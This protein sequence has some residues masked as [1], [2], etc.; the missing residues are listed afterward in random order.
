MK[1]R[2]IAEIAVEKKDAVQKVRELTP[3]IRILKR[4][5]LKTI[6]EIGT[7][8]GG[9]IYVWHKIAQPDAVIISID[10]P[11]GPFGG[12]YTLKEMKVIRGYRR[13]KQKLHLMRKDS[14]RSATRKEL[15]RRLK[16]R[17]IDF[18]MI[19]GDHRYAGVR[20]DWK[21]YSPLVKE[22]GIIAFHDILSHPEVPKCRV[23]RF[24]NEI[25]ESYRHSEFLDRE[26]DRGWGQW[27]GIG[28]IYY[29]K[30]LQ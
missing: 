23:D 18:L 3:L 7:Q 28:I 1:A 17:M 22:N 19:D 25:K 14:H 30:A 6:V 13:S 26:D 8:K 2:R 27:G 24:W 12:G 20:K 9:T 11:G 16:K 29:S 10:L 4:R 15:I 21:M 5:R